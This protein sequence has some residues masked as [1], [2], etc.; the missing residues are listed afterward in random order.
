MT[1]HGRFTI[2]LV[3]ACTAFPLFA[4]TAGDDRINRLE[5]RL[6]ELAKQMTEIRQELR[7][8]KGTSPA[9]APMADDQ[10]L[11]KVEVVQPAPATIATTQQPA[12]PTPPGEQPQSALTDVQTI[13]NA[14]DPGAAKVFNP[15]IAVIGSFLGK[16]GQKNEVEFGPDDLRPPTSLDETEISFEAFVDP[17]AKAKF[18]LSITP[19]GVDVEEGFANFV[20]LPYDLTAKV[21]KLKATFGKDNTWHGHVRPWTDQPLVI[22][23]FF[24]DE[25][26]NDSG[27]SVTKLFPNRLA[28]VEA[29]GEVF[30]GHTGDVFARSNQNDLFYNAHLKAYKDLTENS[31]LEVGTSYARGTGAQPLNGTPG[32]SQFQAVDLTYRYRPLERG[33]YHSLITRFEGIRNDRRDLPDALWGFYAS[34][35]YQFDQR[36][37]TGL[38]ID[39]SD[40]PSA[41]LPVANSTQPGPGARD[42]GVS[43]TLTFW[44]SEFS[45]IRGQLRRTSYGGFKSVTE[46][47]FQL[48]FAIG[49]H[50][51]HT[52]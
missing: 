19:E 48:Q 15:D 31:N 23:N 38:R 30:S 25:G 8:L 52:F 16:A 36:W 34:A 1:T 42:R 13:N 22:H 26:L 10:D 35:D 2:A 14:S 33:I 40:R 21:G 32:T 37:F 24:G 3:I 43:A 17:Y 51:A 46:F 47:L 12:A 9:A 5:G 27:I 11:T 4:Q 28:F 49:A 50:G 44:P 20:N 6:N 7:Q 29:T 39:R 18:F 41:F 45:Q